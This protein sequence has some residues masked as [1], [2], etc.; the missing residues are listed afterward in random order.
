MAAM[1]D[2]TRLVDPELRSQVH[3]SFKALESVV[4]PRMRRLRPHVEGLTRATSILGCEPSDLPDGEGWAEEVLDDM[5]THCRTHVDA[6]LHSG[7][8]IEGR[9]ARTVSDIGLEE[10]VRPGMVLDLRSSAVRGEAIPVAALDAAVQAT[11]R[12]I[13][14]G[15]AVLIRTGQERYSPA[16]AEFY[17]YPGMTGAGTRFLTSRGATILGTDALAWDRPFP[18]MRRAFEASGD[19]AQL[20]DGHFAIRDREAFIVQQ[21]TNLAA[22]PTS[23]FTVGFFPMRLRGTSAAPAR[24]VAFLPDDAVGAARRRV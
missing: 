10:L 8:I 20:W 6:P 2:L 22:L 19:P 11:G 17:H 13:E 4:A 14:P 12:D 1:V 7:R 3:E 5:N 23:G 24:V 9:P 16:D 18:V 15:D 21:L